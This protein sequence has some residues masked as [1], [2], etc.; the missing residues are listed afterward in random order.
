M[1]TLIAF[2]AAVLLLLVEASGALAANLVPLAGIAPFRLKCEN[3]AVDQN[4]RITLRIDTLKAIIYVDSKSGEEL[5]EQ[6][7]S[8]YAA[9]YEPSTDEFGKIITVIRLYEFEWSGGYLMYNSDGWYYD[10]IK[11]GGIAYK[12]LPAY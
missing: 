5:Q 10:P 3:M 4:D 9:Y 8:K 2:T 1:K 6:K 12:C 7:I 11:N